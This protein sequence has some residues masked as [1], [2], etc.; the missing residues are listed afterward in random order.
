MRES[1]MNEEE[2]KTNKCSASD[3]GSCRQ[4]FR[5]MVLWPKSCNKLL[6]Q[7]LYHRLTER[8]LPLCCHAEYRAGRYT[9]A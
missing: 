8:L 6:H 4:S 1:T 5:S 3:P 7:L 2:T 9:S